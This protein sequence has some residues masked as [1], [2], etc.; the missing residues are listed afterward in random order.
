MEKCTVA[1]Y[2]MPRDRACAWDYCEKVRRT[3]A[4]GRITTDFTD[5]RGFSF[6]TKK[7]NNQFLRH[8]FHGLT[9]ISMRH[10]EEQ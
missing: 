1:R 8:G 2:S 9:R 5:E 6:T 3:K 10:K 4:K 7:N